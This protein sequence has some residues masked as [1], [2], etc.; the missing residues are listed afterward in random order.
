MCRLELFVA[1]RPCAAVAAHRQSPVELAEQTDLGGIQSS[2]DPSCRVAVTAELAQHV[3]HAPDRAEIGAG[4]GQR[5]HPGVE[6]AAFWAKRVDYEAQQRPGSRDS[7]GCVAEDAVELRD[8]TVVAGLAD[9]GRI[10]E[11]PSVAYRRDDDGGVEHRKSS[12]HD[13]TRDLAHHRAAARE[14]GRSVGKGNTIRI[15]ATGGKAKRDVVGMT[16]G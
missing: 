5:A 4:D 10:G 1:P 6:G 15:P 8:C 2:G 3:A 13:A 11:A 12:S 16:L 9:G 14:V 7:V